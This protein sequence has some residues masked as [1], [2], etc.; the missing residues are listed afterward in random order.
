MT[1]LCFGGSFNP[2]HHGHLLCAR[3]VAEQ[4]GFDRIL[5]IPSRQPPHK[6]NFSEIAAPHHR[7]AMCLIAVKDD[8]L[9]QVSEIELFRSGPSYTIDTV[10]EFRKQGWPEVAWLIGADMAVSLP[11][12][13]KPDQ[14]LAQTRFV[15]MARPGWAFNFN[16][17]PPPYQQLQS[18]VVTAPLI[19]ISSTQIRERIKQGQSI[20][21]LTPS[22]VEDYII[23]NELY[24]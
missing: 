21:Y 5:L 16:Q 10:Q 15:L 2:I 22:G 3:A 7:L 23:Q 17:M 24:R 18:A 4:A 11:T 13:H 20:K 12:W 14:L 19:D 1:T 6:P 8:P 9:F